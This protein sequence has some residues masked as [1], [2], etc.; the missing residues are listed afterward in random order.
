MQ[1][2]SLTGPLLRVKSA[3]Y[4]ARKYMTS[5]RKKGIFDGRRRRPYS[6]LGTFSEIGAKTA[7]LAFWWCTFL[8]LA[9]MT[10]CGTGSTLSGSDGDSVYGR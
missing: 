8:D 6:T 4:V 5:T 7:R 3:L 2:G 10:L 9:V 1:A